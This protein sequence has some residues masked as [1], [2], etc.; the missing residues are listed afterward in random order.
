MYATGK[1]NVELLKNML[2]NMRA[3][4]RARDIEMG[5]RLVDPS[6]SFSFDT[7]PGGMVI[8]VHRAFSGGSVDCVD[9][10]WTIKPTLMQ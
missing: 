3:G 6:K 4:K 1:Q 10:S 9:Y 5:T 2:E 8:A 7:P